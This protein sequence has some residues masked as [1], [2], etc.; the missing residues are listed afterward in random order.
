MSTNNQ[1]GA[2]K[3]LSDEEFETVS[4]QVQKRFGS[5]EEVSC[6]IDLTGTA[7]EEYLDAP[8]KFKVKFNSESSPRLISVLKKPS[9][10]P[11][12]S[13]NQTPRSKEKN[14]VTF[15]AAGPQT[16][17][18]PEED[19]PLS[20][21][22]SSASDLQGVD[23]ASLLPVALRGLVP[24]SEPPQA[25]KSKS[26]V[27]LSDNKHESSSNEYYA[28]L[29]RNPRRYDTFTAPQG[30]MSTDLPCRPSSSES[31]LDSLEVVQGIWNPSL[32]SIL[33]SRKKES[34]ADAKI[35]KL[36]HN[37]ISREPAPDP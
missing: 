28:S 9:K 12:P 20:P 34:E 7:S 19:E 37:I 10:S 16:K 22:E 6:E 17:I 36:I 14:R 11:E 25:N 27:C 29:F 21:T 3:Q 4:D 35:D 33:D 24:S 15:S 23:L 5:L 1:D 31:T 13:S 26:S 30:P 8:P 2:H 32:D 18:F